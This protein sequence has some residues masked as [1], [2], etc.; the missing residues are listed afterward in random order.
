MHLF[1]QNKHFNFNGLYSSNQQISIAKLNQI[2]LISRWFDC[3]VYF[4]QKVHSV[5][6]RTVNYN[7]WKV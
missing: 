1:E 7:R 2:H 4:V 3:L 5:I 6:I